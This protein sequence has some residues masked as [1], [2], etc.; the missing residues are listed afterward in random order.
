MDFDRLDPTVDAFCRAITDL[1]NDGIDDAPQVILDGFG[2]LFDGL[3]PTTHGPVQPTF[4]ALEHPGSTDLMPQVPGHFLDGPGPVGL[5]GTGAQRVKRPLLLRGLVGRTL[6]PGVLAS[7]KHLIAFLSQL[8]VFLP[9]DLIHS[10]PQT[11]GDM[12]SVKTDLLRCIGKTIFARPD[13]GGP[14]IHA[15]TPNSM[16]LSGG[17]LLIPARKRH[18][19]APDPHIQHGPRNCI[20]NNRQIFMP[21]FVGNFIHTDVRGHPLNSSPQSPLHRTMDDP[22][23]PFPPNPQLPRHRQN[24][25]LLGPPNHIR[26]KGVRIPGTRISP[27]NQGGLNPVLGT[28]DPRK[29]RHHDGLIRTRIQVTPLPGSSQI[30]KGTHLITYWTLQRRSICTRHRHRSTP[31]FVILRVFYNLPRLPESQTLI[32]RHPWHA[33]INKS[34]GIVDS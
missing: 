26:L 8:L 4:P 5:R 29:P 32:Y 15:Y 25:R 6:Q 9:S 2:G 27:R 3:K 10:F 16:Q 23:N 12:K 20:R 21:L 19:I 18:L 33:V 28:L 30:L 34:R 17:Q 31:R 14:H 13:I 22:I 11:L 24:A 1:Q 7:G